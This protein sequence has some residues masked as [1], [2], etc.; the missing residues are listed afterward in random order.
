MRAFL[1]LL[2]VLVTLVATVAVSASNHQT[3]QNLNQ[4]T[5][6]PESETAQGRMLLRTAFDD[7]EERGVMD[8][9]KKMGKSTVKSYHK[10]YV[11]IKSGALD[12][13]KTTSTFLTKSFNPDQVHKWL[14]LD[15]GRSSWHVREFM[16]CTRRSIWYPGWKS[17][18]N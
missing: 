15:D 8:S 17:R 12:M 10:A 14:Q 1:I 16:T 11:N 7:F 5:D 6:A 18:F 4:P 13:E 3:S 2:L 9:P